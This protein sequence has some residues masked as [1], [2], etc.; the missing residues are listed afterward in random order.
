MSQRVIFSLR[1][2]AGN[3]GLYRERHADLWPELVDAIRAQG[4]SNYT[5]VALPDVDRVVG[6]LEVDDLERWTSGGQSDVTAAWWKYMADIM[7]TNA[8]FSPIDCPIVE[9][10]H[11]D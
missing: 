11:L 1:L 6:Y 2:P 7:P 5:I 4:G 10:F 8:D 3:I 9:V